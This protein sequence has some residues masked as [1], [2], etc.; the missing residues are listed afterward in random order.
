MDPTKDEH[1]RHQV[2]KYYGTFSRSMLTMFEITLANWAPAARILA[3]NVNEW[4]MIFNLLHKFVI[5]FAVV[6]VIQGVFMQQTFKVAATDDTIMTMQQ[7]RATEI[8]RKKMQLLFLA[9]DED[10]NGLLD[11]EEFEKILGERAVRTWLAAMELQVDD[12]DKIFE[13]LCGEDDG[14]TAD[15]L[16]SGVSKLKGGARS[17]DLHVLMIEHRKLLDGIAD[18]QQKLEKVE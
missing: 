1:V 10:G 4:F 9:A 2:Y 18:L 3:E 16:V 6:L 17:L 12:V 14:M 13:L 7:T 5:G 15:E 11:R 8:H